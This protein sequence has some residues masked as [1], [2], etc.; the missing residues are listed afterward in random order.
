MHGIKKYRKAL[1]ELIAILLTVIIWIPIALIVL[2]AMK[3]KKGAAELSFKLPDPFYFFDNLKVLI[4]EGDL[5]SGLINSTVITVTTVILVIAISSITAFII[6]R[7]KSMISKGINMMLLFGMI[8]PPAI[9]PTVLMMKDIGITN[10]LVAAIIALYTFNFSVAV[11]LYVGYFN[12]IPIEID[13]AALIDGC[14]PVRMFYNVIFPLLKPVTVTITIITFMA[15]W[16]DF[17]YSIYFLNK[18]EKYTLVLWTYF[19]AGARAS[20]WN[21]VFANVVIVTIPVAVIYLLLQKHI[22]SGMTSGAVKG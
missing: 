4:V 6:Q 12:T 17:G 19:F 18:P 3:D 20:D 16:N 10:P 9:I 1:I 14:N 13:E 2:S 22:I 11:F 15:V 5:I 7:R 21:L 8:I